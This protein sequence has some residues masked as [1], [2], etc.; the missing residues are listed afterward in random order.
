MQDSL[1]SGGAMLIRESGKRAKLA[2]AVPS[3]AMMA[4]ARAA[5]AIMAAEDAETAAEELATKDTRVRT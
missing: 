5:Q 4:K 3:K 1:A 2:A